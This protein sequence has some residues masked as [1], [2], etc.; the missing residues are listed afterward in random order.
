MHNK[1]L[2]IEKTTLTDLNTEIQYY[3]QQAAYRIAEQY[4]YRFNDLTHYV[5]TLIAS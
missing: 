3:M 1:I 4:S 5:A 2:V